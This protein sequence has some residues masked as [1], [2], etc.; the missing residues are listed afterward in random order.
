[1]D[2]EDNK[3]NKPLT[4]P[5]KP[6]PPLTF[7]SSD[8]KPYN[9]NYFVRTSNKLSTHIK[10]LFKNLKQ[11]KLITLGAS[12]VLI[13][14]AIA[15]PIVIINFSKNQPQDSPTTP[16][17]KETFEY[18][19]STADLTGET[20]DIIDEINTMIAETDTNN[21]QE[22]YRLYSL[23]YSAQFNAG[24]YADALDTLRLTEQY[25][26]EDEL[27]HVYA[28]IADTYLAIDDE[29]SAAEYLKKALEFPETEEYNY[30]AAKLCLLTGEMCEAE[31]TNE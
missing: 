23:Q 12:L 15:L 9:P 5:E 16:S 6:T 25:A 19:V 1:M 7:R 11:H 29:C 14:A 27:A 13:A 24:R 30:Y 2:N 3:P 28:N 22:L 18:R 31:A 17:I 20:D 26:Q 8:I 21:N 10:H 4:K